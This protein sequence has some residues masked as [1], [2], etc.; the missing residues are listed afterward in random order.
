MEEKR[1]DIILERW[2][3]DLPAHRERLRNK[4]DLLI[5]RIMAS[6]TDADIGPLLSGTAPEIV[7]IL[8][9]RVKNVGKE[10]RV[11]AH[12]KAGDPWKKGATWRE[13]MMTYLLR[14]TFH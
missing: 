7:A 3:D 9:D 6:H 10:L 8:Y 14:G 12:L 11:M 4:V 1:P 13:L 5:K 2:G